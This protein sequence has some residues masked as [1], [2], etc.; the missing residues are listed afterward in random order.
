MLLLF[1]SYPQ[2]YLRARRDISFEVTSVEGIGP[3]VENNSIQ[4]KADEL[5]LVERSYKFSPDDA[6]RLF[7]QAGLRVIQ[8][9]SD[10][11]DPVAPTHTLYLIERAE[12]HFFR[13]AP[14]PS[15]G[16][17]P[18]S[19]ADRPVIHKDASSNWQLLV[20]IWDT[21]STHSLPIRMS[22]GDHQHKPPNTSFCKK[23][24]LPE[25]CYSVFL[26][27]FQ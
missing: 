21:I 26:S 9:W 24:T 5:I 13:T 11:P 27:D 25:F 10:S 22:D 23:I 14:W 2:A 1:A 4:I 12:F 20:Q 6:Y 17:L 15:M 7:D 19:P 18:L 3:E 8:K 16:D